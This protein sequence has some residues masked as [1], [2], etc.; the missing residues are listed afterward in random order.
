MKAVSIIIGCIHTKRT[1]AIPAMG[2][3]KIIARIVFLT[4]E[5]PG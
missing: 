2:I 4:N 1:A 5:A 3:V